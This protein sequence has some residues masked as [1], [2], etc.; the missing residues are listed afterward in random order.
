MTNGGSEGNE[1][2]LLVAGT[3]AG[4]GALARALWAGSMV[5]TVA[6]TP[7][8]ALTCAGAGGFRVIV[9]DLP[10]GPADLRALLSNLRGRCDAP[11]ILVAHGPF[12]L[13]PAADCVVSSDATEAEIVARARALL[14]IGRPPGLATTL[15]WGPL[16]LDLRRRVARWYLEPLRLTSIQFRM[17][18]VLVLAGGSMVT[19]QELARRIW[20]SGIVED[21]DRIRAHVWRVRKLIEA[22]PS[23][24]EFLLTVRGEG[25]RLADHDIEEPD[26]DLDV[27]AEP[28]ESWP[29]GQ[30]S[31]AR[32]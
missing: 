32:V 23:A 9:V 18:E 24:P 8:Q 21:E 27:L 25:F 26:V 5:P 7:G 22:R 19:A 2:V 14:T 30:E 4:A 15:S 3:D 16:E 28:I 1:K 29:G 12:E 6:F 31:S 11:L 13:D 20:G 17:M 10:I